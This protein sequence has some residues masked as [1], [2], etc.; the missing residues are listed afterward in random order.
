MLP[1]AH[2]VVSFILD[3]KKYDVDGFS[4][5]FSQPTDYKGQPQHEIKGGQFSVRL[6]Q[7]PDDNLYSW[8][9]ES[10]KLKD[11]VILFQTDLGITVLKIV[12]SEAYCV[13]LSRNV[14]SRSGSS[15]ELVVSPLFI[16]IDEIE[17]NNYWPN[18]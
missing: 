8:A 14:S 11:G 3:E 17:Y 12:F 6:Y 9:K 13:D 1:L 2:I 7:T 10:T 18:K 15:T 4:I 5:N 16:S